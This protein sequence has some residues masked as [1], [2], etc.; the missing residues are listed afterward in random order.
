M[1]LKQKFGNIKV[2]EPKKSKNVY[3]VV[4]DG[5][6]AG[7]FSETELKT[8][9][10]NGVV[11]SNTL[12]WSPGMLNW[13]IAQSIPSVNKLLLLSQK[14]EKLKK[15]KS[16]TTVSLKEDTNPIREDIIKAVVNLG[17]KKSVT[18]EIVNQVL[19]NNPK[20]SIEEGI[21]EVLK[22]IN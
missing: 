3:Y 14:P 19:E 2:F 9:V 7:P 21:K 4:V 20:I 13:Q 6:Q 1:S 18:V 12:V 8:L 17:Y 5:L 15:E 22:R 16:D 11:T 10:K